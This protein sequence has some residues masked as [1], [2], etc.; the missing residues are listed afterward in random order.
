MEIYSSLSNINICYFL[1]IRI[2]MCHRH[3]FRIISQNP[4]NIEIFCN[5]RL[6]L[7]IFYVVDGS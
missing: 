5:D 3:F 7:F 1:K 4:E 6:V 2:P